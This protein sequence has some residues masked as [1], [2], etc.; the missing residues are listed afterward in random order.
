MCFMHAN[1]RQYAA[2]II[3][4]LIYDYVEGLHHSYS[5]KNPA[6]FANDV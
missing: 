4:Y 3:G 1:R 2:F 5:R 6:D